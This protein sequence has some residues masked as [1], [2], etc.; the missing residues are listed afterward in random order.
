MANRTSLIMNIVLSIAVAVLFYLHFSTK[1]AGV[2]GT[3]GTTAKNDSLVKT[4]STTKTQQ[5]SRIVYLNID[6]LFEKYEYYKKVSDEANASLKAYESNYQKQVADFQQ[7]YQDYMEKA[8]QGMYTKEQGLKIEE[9]LQNQ[10]TKI[11]TM[12]MNRTSMQD[13]ASA[14]LEVVQK[15][16]YDFFKA[17][18]KAN[19]YACILTY[20]VKGEGALGIDDSLDVT[21]QIIKGLNEEYH[22]ELQEAPKKK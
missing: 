6:T 21:H 8:Q 17:F 15:K 13:A 11:E 1:P 22:K 3:D 2:T 5:E 16:L 4:I 12:E 7:K 9:D 20:T 18:T 19:D 14:K 10:K